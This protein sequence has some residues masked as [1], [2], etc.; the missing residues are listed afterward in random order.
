MRCSATQGIHHRANLYHRLL[1]KVTPRT[2]SLVGLLTLCMRTRQR[3]VAYSVQN[4][5]HCS[6]RVLSPSRMRLQQLSYSSTSV[7]AYR[8]APMTRKCVKLQLK[9]QCATERGPLRPTLHGIGRNII[10][11]G[12]LSLTFCEWQPSRISSTLCC[13]FNCSTI[14]YLLAG[15]ALQQLL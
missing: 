10:I 3:T 15:A 5:F 4:F 8:G 2:S 13:I 7:K 6:Y 11:R 12:E 9:D 1:L 14:F